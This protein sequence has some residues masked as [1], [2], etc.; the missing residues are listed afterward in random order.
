MK[1]HTEQTVWP[2]AIGKALLV[3]GF[4]PQ[5]ASLSDAA[6]K[7]QEHG[8]GSSKWYAATVSVSNYTYAS[9]C[10]DMS[11]VSDWMKTL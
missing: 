7:Y 4:L 8:G 5:R 6:C 9:L 1:W 10:F 11:K 3:M 2:V